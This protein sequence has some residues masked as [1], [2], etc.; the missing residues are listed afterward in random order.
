MITTSCLMLWIVI[1]THGMSA[2]LS[3]MIR[4]DVRESIWMSIMELRRICWGV[5]GRVIKSMSHAAQL[6]GIQCVYYV[7]FY[8]CLLCTYSSF[9]LYNGVCVHSIVK[10]WNASSGKL[11]YY[12]P[13][14]KGSVNEVRTYVRLSVGQW[15]SVYVCLCMVWCI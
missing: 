14:H 5:L 7:L 3:W 6:T 11:L 10:I 4:W 2:P 1:Y 12:L 13:G 9:V 8:V 15:G